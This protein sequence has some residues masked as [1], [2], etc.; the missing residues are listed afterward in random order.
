MAIIKKTKK[1]LIK[2]NRTLTKS[3]ETLCARCVML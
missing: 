2:D 1:D 3:N